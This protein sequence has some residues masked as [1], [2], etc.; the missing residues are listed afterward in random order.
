MARRPLP[1][2]GVV[3][4]AGANSG[5]PGGAAVAREFQRQAH[6][7]H[8]RAAYAIG[9]ALA[10]PSADNW[11]RLIAIF[12][13][14]LTR[15]E[16]MELARAALTAADQN[17]ARQVAHDVLGEAGPPL[18]PFGPIMPEAEAWAYVASERERKAYAA[19][20]IRSMSEAIL[21]ALLGWLRGIFHG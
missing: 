8:Q 2:G 13:A 11:L 16:L 1:G 3:G 19:A 5:A 18:T 9:V 4:R 20:A 14:R 17:D 7:R 6:A 21:A 15:R 12:G 10:Q